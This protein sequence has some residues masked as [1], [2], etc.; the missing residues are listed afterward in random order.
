MALTIH[1][2]LAPRLKKE[3]NYTASPIWA[4]MACS[5]V[6]FTFTFTQYNVQHSKTVLKF[7]PGF[8]DT[9]S[10]PQGDQ[11]RCPQYIDYSTEDGQDWTICREKF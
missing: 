4:F 5:R 6:I 8:L 11:L 2:H 10:Y 9:L 3:Q 7:V 1:P